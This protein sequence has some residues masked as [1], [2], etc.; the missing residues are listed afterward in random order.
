MNQ[1]RDYKNV[2]VRLLSLLGFLTTWLITVACHQNKDV[3]SMETDKVVVTLNIKGISAEGLKFVASLKNEG[4]SS[5]YVDDSFDARA[6]LIFK[7]D[8]KSVEVMPM[9]VLEVGDSKNE[10][11]SVCVM[12]GE[13]KTWQFTLI[14]ERD[15]GFVETG[16][17]TPLIDYVPGNK[18]TVQF[19]PLWR[20]AEGAKE[21]SEASNSLS[22]K[23]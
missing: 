10:V 1:Q 11:E 16:Y 20:L 21:Q 22:C 2:G 15:G 4:S 8:G 3:T 14:Y 19:Q 23:F 13:K 9:D 18:I 17:H 5:I 6:W 7:L 12:P